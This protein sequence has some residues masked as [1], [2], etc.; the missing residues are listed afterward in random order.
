MEAFFQPQTFLLLGDG[1][2]QASFL[3]AKHYFKNLDMSRNAFFLFVWFFFKIGVE[4]LDSTQTF[5]LNPIWYLRDELE[6]HLL[7][8]QWTAQDLWPSVILL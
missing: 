5:D 4:E 1:A 6:H 8:S 2:R 3:L 7:A